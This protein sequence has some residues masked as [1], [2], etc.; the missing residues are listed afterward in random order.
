MPLTGPTHEPRRTYHLQAPQFL[1]RHLVTI[2]RMRIMVLVTPDRALTATAA[3]VVGVGVNV[4]E[5][6]PATVVKFAMRGPSE[7]KAC[8]WLIPGFTFVDVEVFGV[9]G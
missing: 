6:V 8:E 1:M 3:S 9:E 2:L 4:A 5:S 7:V